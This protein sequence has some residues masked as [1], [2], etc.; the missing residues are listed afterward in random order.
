MDPNLSL[1]L[2]NGGWAKRGGSPGAAGALQ[3]WMLSELVDSTPQPGDVFTGGVPLSA[4]GVSLSTVLIMQQN[5]LVACFLWIAYR[6]GAEWVSD[7]RADGFG[8]M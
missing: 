3:Q 7:K 5:T 2:A 8:R 4:H 6:W 1:V